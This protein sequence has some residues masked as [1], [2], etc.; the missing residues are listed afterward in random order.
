MTTNGLIRAQG[1]VLSPG[2]LAE[3]QALI[4]EHP[5]WSRH[6]IARELCQAWEWCT[7]AGQ[8]K[9]FAARTLLLTLEERHQLRLPPVREQYRQQPWGIRMESSS[10]PRPTT[11][12]EGSLEVLQPLDWEVCSYQTDQRQRA[13]GLLRQF[14]YLGCNRPVGTH[15]LYL[16]KD[17][18]G[19]E[20]AVHLIGAAAWQ[21][22]PRDAYIGWPPSQRAV[23]LP[24]I[25]NHSRFLILPWVRVPGLAAHLLNQLTR[26]LPKDWLGYH[27]WKLFLLE[28]FVETGRFV[29]AAYRAAGWQEVGQTTGRTRQEKHGQVQAAPKSVWVYP[30]SSDFRRQLS[31]GGA[32]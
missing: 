23:H 9:T 16:V 13:L 8:A 7:C 17:A 26:R 3:L 12:I 2:E 22:A 5:E 1:R 32:P 18:Q 25:A 21:C 29:G 11:Q 19:R 31:P 4:D 24:A 27:G 28:S 6:R 15:L 14:H 20:L 30:L 10:I